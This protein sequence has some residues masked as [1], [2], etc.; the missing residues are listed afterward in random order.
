M[1]SAQP[2]P[3]DRAEDRAPLPASFE[4]LF[5]LYVFGDDGDLAW[6]VHTAPFRTFTADDLASHPS[7]PSAPGAPGVT[8]DTGDLPP[9]AATGPGDPVTLA[10]SWLFTSP[11]QIPA[12]LDFAVG[13][14]A[15]GVE[16]LITIAVDL[17]AGDP[18]DQPDRPTSQQ[19][20]Q[21]TSRSRSRLPGDADAD[22]A[23]RMLDG[24]VAACLARGHRVFVR[25]PGQTS[26]VLATLPVVRP[27]DPLVELV[28]GW[29]DIA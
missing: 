2:P 4:G 8:G 28:R 24:A 5:T 22:L 20:S 9:V 3:S 15:F 11:D 12:N 1:T 18:L 23:S 21:Q 29:P 7:V 13:G 27:D 19:T 25:V 17:T 6:Q 16:D 10:R 14:R 26:A